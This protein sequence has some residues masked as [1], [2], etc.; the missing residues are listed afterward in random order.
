MRILFDRIYELLMRNIP[1]E[2]VYDDAGCTVE[3]GIDIKEIAKLIV[4]QVY[5]YLE[6]HTEPHED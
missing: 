4:V 1:T 3:V 5:E 2:V 6:P